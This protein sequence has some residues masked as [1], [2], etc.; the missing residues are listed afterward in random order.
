MYNASTVTLM[1]KM[2]SHPP[3]IEVILVISGVTKSW[4]RQPILSAT[5]SGG[6]GKF[7]IYGAA[8]NNSITGRMNG[9]T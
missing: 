7:K 2:D 6:H 3:C 5:P 1:L 9:R 4:R 8:L